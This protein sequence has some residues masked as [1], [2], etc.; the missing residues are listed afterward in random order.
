MRP[1]GPATIFHDRLFLIFLVGVFVVGIVFFQHES[2]LPLYLVQ[3]L[4]LSPAFYG[5]LFTINTLLIV[6]LEVP[7]NTATAHWSNTRLLVIGS[8]LFAIGFGALAVIAS[9]A[10]VIA[11][12]VVWTFG[13]MLLFPSVCCPHVGDR[14]GESP[15]RLHGRLHDGSQHRAHG[16]TVDGDSAARDVRARCRL[17]RHVCP[18]GAGRC[19]D[20]VCR[21]S[22]PGTVRCSRRWILATIISIAIALCPPRGTITSAYRLLGSTN[23]RCIG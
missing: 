7:L 12:V 22:C 11:T 4:S 10:G 23:C 3:Y 9:P 5:M 2:A 21:A 15:W 20:G 13:E 8:M 19:A 6:A 1:L 14:A 16:G 17:V 18:R